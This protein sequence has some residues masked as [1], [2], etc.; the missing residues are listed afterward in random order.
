MLFD[1]EG[2]HR[3]AALTEIDQILSKLS[4]PA[5]IEPKSEGMTSYTPGIK[6]Q[7]LGSG[8]FLQPMAI[9]LN[10]A[11]SDFQ[12]QIPKM[13]KSNKL[14]S[15]KKI[16]ERKQSQQELIL[17]FLKNSDPSTRAEIAEVLDILDSSVTGQLHEL[18]SLGLVREHSSKFDTNTER[19]VTL[20][21]FVP[22][23]A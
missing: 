21:T 19:F 15:F 18:V 14:K 20:Y 23:A 4:N 6:M 2:E 5:T 22:P 1:L 13:G 9:C 17:D 10:D 12:R 16:Q 11:P 7:W 3:A 8:E